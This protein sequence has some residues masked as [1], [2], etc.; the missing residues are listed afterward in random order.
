MARMGKKEGVIDGEEEGIE[1]EKE[2]RRRSM[3]EKVNRESRR[4]MEL[5]EE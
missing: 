4:F 3:D 2:K 5:M 1:M